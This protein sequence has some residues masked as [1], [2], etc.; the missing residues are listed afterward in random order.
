MAE[1]APR[2]G[3]PVIVIPAR[4][5]ESASALRYGAVVAARALVDAVF[6]AGGEPV[7]MSPYAAGGQVSDEEVRQRLR[8]ADAVLLPG[9]GDLDPRWSA[10]TSHPTQYDV[11]VEQDAFDFAVARVALDDGLPMLAI[12]RGLQVVNVLLG[13]TIVQDMTNT[14]AGD[15]RHRTH[16]IAPLIKG[17]AEPGPAI[18]ISC[19]HHQ[20]VGRVGNGLE[21]VARSEDGVVEAVRLADQTG[22]TSWFLAVQWHPEDTAARDANQSAIFRE[23][24]DA[25]RR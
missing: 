17:T 6:A 2:R 8:I 23:F 24:V 3:R 18:E 14:V 19:Y 22:T 12:C 15:H 7:V 25:A 13:G 21:I 10:Q 4:F 11:D 16:H 9:G 20:C 1:D 5:S